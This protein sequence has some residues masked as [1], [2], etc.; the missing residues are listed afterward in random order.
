MSTK[1]IRNDE[2]T[3]I[4]VEPGTILNLADQNKD[5]Y[6]ISELSKYVYKPSVPMTGKLCFKSNSFPLINQV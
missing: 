6:S 5:T 3:Q 2:L 1:Y 4:E